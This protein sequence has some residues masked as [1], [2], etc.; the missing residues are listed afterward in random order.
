MC[1]QAAAASKFLRV[2]RPNI[3]D[4]NYRKISCEAEAGSKSRDAKYHQERSNWENIIDEK[5]RGA[6]TGSLKE[7]LNITNCT[8]FYTHFMRIENFTLSYSSH[9]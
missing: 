3:V 8:V 6:L 5:H 2:E 1:R 9:L 7:Q 4:I